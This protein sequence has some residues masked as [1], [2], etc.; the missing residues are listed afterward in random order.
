MN[1]FLSL[2]SNVQP[3]QYYLQRAL[4]EL[5]KIGRIIKF[6]AIYESNP[7]GVE[8][9]PPFLNMV[10]LMD[11]R[12]RPFRLLRNL[13]N[14]EARLGRQRSFHWGPREID[15]D[16]IDWDSEEINT[17]ILSLPHKGLKLRRFVLIPL[18]QIAPEYCSRS[19]QP[20]AEIIAHCPDKGFVEQVNPEGQLN[21]LNS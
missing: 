21:N 12:L 18:Q 7:F 15:V 4:A 8:N 3:R 9:Q 2:G 13:K 20:L 16:L 6:S 14:I 5:S 10:C 11:S 19:G 17:A 1:Y